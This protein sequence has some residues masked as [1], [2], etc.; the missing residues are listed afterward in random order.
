[1]IFQIEARDLPCL[2]MY[3]RKDVNSTGKLFLVVC[4]LGI[5]LRNFTY[6]LIFIWIHSGACEYTYAD[7]EIDLVFMSKL[8]FW[9]PLGM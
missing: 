6:F 2:F 9:F 1:M 7:S 3:F 8:G 5:Y 4:N